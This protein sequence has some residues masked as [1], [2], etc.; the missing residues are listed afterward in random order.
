MIPYIDYSSCT[1]CGAC[2]ALYPEFFVMR[3][4]KPWFINY[5]A[6]SVEIHKKV[7]FSC[8]FRA[9]SLS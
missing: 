8:P 2:A 5:E 9:I 6:F 4:E 1:G 3:D 7:I